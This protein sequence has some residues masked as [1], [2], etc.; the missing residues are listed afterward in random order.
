MENF[1]IRQIFH[2]IAKHGKLQIPFFSHQA[3]TRT[4]TIKS[5]DQ[6][7]LIV[8]FPHFGRK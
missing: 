6:T 2:P 3:K 7:V 1:K 5:M 4:E 8:P